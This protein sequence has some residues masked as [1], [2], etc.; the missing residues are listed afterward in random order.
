MLDLGSSPPSN[1]FLSGETINHPEKWY[2]L[3]ILVCENCWL[4]QTEDFVDAHEMFSDDYAYFS[5]YSLLFLNQLCT[6]VSV[7]L[8]LSLFISKCAHRPLAVPNLKTRNDG[9]G[10]DVPI[11]GT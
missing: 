4:V 11:S 10:F 8:L 2:P 6:I 9:W 1:S 3:N 7:W 5:S